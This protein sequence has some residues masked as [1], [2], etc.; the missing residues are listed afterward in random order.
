MREIA[1]IVEADEPAI[2]FSNVRAAAASMEAVD[3]D[4]GLYR[5]LFGPAGEVFEVS[6]IDGRAHIALVEGSNDLSGLRRV[7]VSFLSAMNIDHEVDESVS[8]LLEK[9]RPFVE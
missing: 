9:C 1:L 3:V 6:V 7:L 8:L 4:N 2:F 5:K